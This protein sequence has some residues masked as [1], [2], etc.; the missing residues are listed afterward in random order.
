VRRAPAALALAV[1]LA[2]A[3]ARG[4]E[5]KPPP[6]PASG[7]E[8]L[9]LR[10]TRDAELIITSD[11]AEGVKAPGGRES[12][13]FTKHVKAHQGDMK[14]EC[15]WLEAVYPQAA[16]GRPDK[17]SAKGSVVIRQGSNEARCSDAQIDNVACTAECRS[18]GA[19]ATLQR[20]TDDIE[21]D[22]IYFDLCKG[23]VKAVGSV[24]IRVREKPGESVPIGPAAAPPQQGEPQ[25]G[26]AKA[27]GG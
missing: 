19:K 8:R 3:G 17:I 6:A 22:T 2:A 7:V 24:Q 15:D 20:G 13:V 4:E 14:L 27:D 1:A 21:A 16:A 11:E 25:P 10:F 26:P 5:T 18:E 9:G 23:T 12:V